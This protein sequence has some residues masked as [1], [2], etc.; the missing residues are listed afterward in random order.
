MLKAELISCYLYAADVAYGLSKKEVRAFHNSL[1][2]RPAVANSIE[3]RGILNLSA[4]NDGGM[5]ATIRHLIKDHNYRR[6]AFI[7]G[8]REQLDAQQRYEAYKKELAANDIRFAKR[9]VVDGDFSQE[10]GRAAMRELLDDRKVRIDAVAAANDRMAFGV[11]DVLQAR[12]LRVPAEMAVTGFD[13]VTEAQLLGVPLTTVRQS[14]YD[15]GYRGLELLLKRI[16]GETVP[17]RSVFPTEMIVR[18]SCGCLPESVHK[19]VV[20]PEEVAKTG[21]LEN[22][23]D[24]AVRALLSAGGIESKHPAIEQ[25]KILFGACWDVFLAVMRDEAKNNAFLNAIEAAVALL[26]QHNRDAAA[27][28]NVISV[29]RRHTLAG[30]SEKNDLLKAEN[31]F[32]Q[33]RMMTGELS[34]RDQADYRQELEQQ[35]EAE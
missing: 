10:S 27:W 28:H 13:D 34:Q 24:A 16:D 3:G 20:A 25:F 30:I 9:L 21:Q 15:T 5:R 22:K 23:R 18:W 1:P 11:L 35:E 17:H 19:A 4:D 12:G 29:L 31:L 6:I 8:P 7:R 14:F 26:Q 33:A 2:E 32:Q